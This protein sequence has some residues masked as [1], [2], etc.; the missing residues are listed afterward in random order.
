MKKWNVVILLMLVLAVG[1]CK[2]DQ[3]VIQTNFPTLPNNPFPGAGPDDTTVSEMPDSNTIVG[4][5]QYIFS[6]KCALG[7]CHDGAFE[8]DFRTVQSAYST[9]IFHPIVKNNTSGEFTYRVIPFDTANSVLH[10]RVNNYNFVNQG[11]IMPQDVM[12]KLPQGDLDA[13][14]KWILGGA[15]DIFGNVPGEPNF[16]PSVFGLLAFLPDSGYYRIDTA[17]TRF[18]DPFIVPQGVNLEIWFG[19]TDDKTSPA[20]FT[21]NKVKFATQL[22]SWGGQ[23]EQSLTVEQNVPLWGPSFEFNP[24][25]YYHHIQINTSAY[26]K[27]DIVFMRAYVQDGDH[28][29]DPTELPNDGSQFFFQT[30]FAFQIDTL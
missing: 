2:K 5:H 11:D 9:L 26:N 8:P 14:A 23:T 22:Y 30:Y 13:I 28:L 27:G 20:N 24:I 18:F 29:P 12:Q 15:K 16:E 10:E 6:T 4:L 17:R 7:A 25:P 19:L 3:K 1:S 21:Y